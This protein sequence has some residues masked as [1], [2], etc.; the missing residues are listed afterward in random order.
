MTI[1]RNLTELR[2]HNER[3]DRALRDSPAAAARAREESALLLVRWLGATETD[4]AEF[5]A[6]F[7]QPPADDNPWPLPRN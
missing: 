6:L 5:A 2:R 3:T 1:I 7:G 4:R